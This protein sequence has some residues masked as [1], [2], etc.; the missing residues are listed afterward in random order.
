M[1]LIKIVNAVSNL[2]K[3]SEMLLPAKESFKVVK[4]LIEIDPHINNFNLQRNK[5]LAKYGNTED[6]E[7]FVIREEDREAFL[8][9]IN[10]LKN[11]EIEIE[12][13]KIKISKGLTVKASDL[14]NIL[15]FIKIEE[16]D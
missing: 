16:G 3:L 10:E 15:D 13:E 8:K 14:I 11:I 6:D 4:L 9:E 5:L 1:K 2:N 12:Y 7:T